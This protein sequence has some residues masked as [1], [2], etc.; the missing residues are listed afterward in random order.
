MIS[1]ILFPFTKSVI[2][3]YE[4]SGLFIYMFNKNSILKSREYF[5]R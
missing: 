1:K 5:I 2:D 3:E 4:E